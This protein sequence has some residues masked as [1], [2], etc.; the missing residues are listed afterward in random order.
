MTSFRCILLVVLSATLM[1]APVRAQR[2]A[3]D[4]PIAETQVPWDRSRP[5]DPFV[6]PDG[7][8]WFVGQVGNYVAV[9]DPA[10]NDFKKFDLEPGALPHNNIVGPDGIVWYAGNAN[11][12]I[13]RLDPKTGAI[14]AIKMPAGVSDPHTMM[15]DGRG[16]IWFTAQGANV[17][18]RLDLA[19]EQ[20]R[21]VAMPVERSRPYGLIIDDTGRPWFDLF[22][23][24]KLGTIDP[25]SFALT[26]FDLPDGARPRRIGR[27]TDG[28][29]WYVDYSRGFLGRLDP[30]TKDVEEWAAPSGP[31]S[32]PYAMAIDDAD[33]IWYVETGVQPNRMVGFDPKTKSVISNTPITGGEGRNA[34]RHMV[35][36]PK[37]RS[38]WYGSDNGF[39]GKVTVP[40]K[41]IL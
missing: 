15:F 39:L 17:V 6:A 8:I 30:A 23:T 2:A 12:T 13:G 40:P 9:F 1:S 5:R 26:L 27:T 20:V 10:T 35:F 34:V 18:G 41:P 36:D 7:K 11:G 31:R 33:R 37:T 38:I 25:A 24:N 4:V 22:G 19:T 29:M 32:Q 16:G 28:G 3:A 21:V 14:K